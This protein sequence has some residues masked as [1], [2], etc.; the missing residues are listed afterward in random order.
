[1]VKKCG[2]GNI[3]PAGDDEGSRRIFGSIFPRRST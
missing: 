2:R 3:A 1:M